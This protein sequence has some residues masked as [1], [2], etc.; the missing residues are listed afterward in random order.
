MAIT[1]VTQPSQYTPIYNGA[2]FT[3]T[4]D[5]VTE[6]SFSFIFDIYVDAALLTRH[7]IAPRPTDGLGIFDAGKI[8][9]SLIT[10]DPLTDID[11]EFLNNASYKK[12]QVKIGEEVETGGAMV[13]TADLATSS[14]VYAFNGTLRYRDFVAFDHTDYLL[15]NANRKFI[16]DSGIPTIGLGERAWLYS[17]NSTPASYDKIVIKTYDS[18]GTL[19]DTFTNTNTLNDNGDDNDRFIRAAVGP[20]HIINQQGAGSLDGVSYYT[21]QAQTA[22]SGAMSEVKRFN[23]VDHCTRYTPIRIHF[24]NRFG[25]FDSFTFITV[26]RT[27]F[28]KKTKTFTRSQNYNPA[29]SDRMKT[30]TSTE[31][32]EKILVNSDWLTE[33]ESLWLEQLLSSPVIFQEFNNELIPVVCTTSNYQTRKTEVDKLFNL[34]LEFEYTYTNIRQRY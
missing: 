32:T 13:L 9:E 17:M 26:S 10:H 20:F 24:L 27:T 15:G 12:F 23:L 2:F 6:P 5:N 29:V 3:C 18:S 31:E 34:Q 4:S 25:A 21:V 16:T 28:E 30:V 7:R 22:V 11:S 8:I 19:L 14:N 33:S 1:I